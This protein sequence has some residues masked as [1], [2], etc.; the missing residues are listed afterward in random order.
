VDPAT[1]ALNAAT[2]LTAALALLFSRLDSRHQQ[3]TEPVDFR[4]ALWQMS[5]LVHRWAAQAKT[6][7]EVMQ[8]WAQGNLD[9]LQASSTMRSNFSL[10]SM[11]RDRGRVLMLRK[12]DDDY[13]LSHL[14][15]LY[16][17]EVQ[18]ALETGLARRA[19]L[20][21]ELAVDLP[22]L[23][24]A[25]PEVLQTTVRRLQSASR[26][27][28]HASKQLDQYIRDHFPPDDGVDT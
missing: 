12:G 16:G 14:L 6:T 8:S 17:P 18:E 20:I 25:Q 21:V 7:D 5:W 10:Q 15:R 1:L 13:G 11:L 3:S 27:L 23:R 19:E 28:D 9:D 4:Q 2:T 22:H 26:E 24:A